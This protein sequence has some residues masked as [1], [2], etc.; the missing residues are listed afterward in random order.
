MSNLAR[1]VDSFNASPH[2]FAD[3]ARGRPPIAI[4]CGGHR[5]DASRTTA[6][7]RTLG[8]LLAVPELLEPPA[9][10]VAHFVIERRTTLLCGREKSGKSTLTAQA[11]AAASNGRPFL[12]QQRGDPLRVVWY[13]IDEPLGDTVRR[14][15]DLGAHHDNV[16]INDAPRSVSE[17]FSAMEADLLEHPGVRLVVIDT[18]SRL[19]EVSGVDANDARSAG[20]FMSQLIALFRLHGVAAVL[21]YHTGKGGREYRGS[22]SIGANVDE[23]LT[24]RRRGAVPD[25]DDFDSAYD[26]DG[27]RVLEQN[28]RALR[29]RVHLGFRAGRYGCFDAGASPRD[30]ILSALQSGPAPS[31]T[32]LVRRAATKKST[33]LSAIEALLHDGLI[34]ESNGAIH[35]VLQFPAG[36]P[37]QP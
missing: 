12:D 5:Q 1:A 27:R 4:D 25:E 10:L 31:R 13:A 19:F 35:V 11:I 9:V 37:D 14:F 36:A 32:A 34:E 15:H 8:Q 18:L 24:L 33:G 2:D 30:R 23:I 21:L 17:L 3:L 6:P 22:T 26:D 28:G 16:I 7:A 20:P 29:G